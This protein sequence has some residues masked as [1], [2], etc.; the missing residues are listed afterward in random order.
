MEQLQTNNQAYHLFDCVP[1]G[2]CVLDANCRVLFWNDYL[3]ERM[4]VSK[5]E[6]IGQP[7]TAYLPFQQPELQAQLQPVFAGQSVE[8]CLQQ[9]GSFP[10]P[11]AKVTA[12]RLAACD[13]AAA[14]HILLSIQFEANP[15][16]APPFES[17]LLSVRK[18][19]SEVAYWQ[20][21]R[22]TQLL[23]GITAA[24]RDSIDTQQVFQTT[25]NHIACTFQVSRCLIHSYSSEPAPCIPVM[26][27]YVAPGYAPSLNLQVPVSGNPHAEQVL[28]QDRAVAS[29]N[30]TIEP[31]LQN[32]QEL[33]RTFQIR[34][35][36]AVRT[37]YQ[38]EA[39]GVIGLHQCDRLRNWT[40]EEI[41]LLEAVAK[42]VGIV[43]AQTRLLE[44]ERR[45]RQEVT[46]K[47]AALEQARW[48]AEAANQAKSNFLATMSH[49]IR[50]PM[51]A[52]IGMT[53]LLLDTELTPQ[54]QDFVET[55]R[56]SGDTLLTIINDILDFS[57]IEAGKLDLEQR[58][59]DL[60]TCIEGILDL[61]AAKAA[62]KGL[63]LAYVVEPDVPQQILGDMTRLRQILIN[64]IGNAIKFTEQG[65]ITVSVIAR[66]LREEEPINLPQP[67]AQSVYAIRFAVKD[68]GIGIPSDQLNRLFHPFSQ[69]DSSISR[70]YGGTGLG[71]VI[72]QRLSEMM[73][74][75]IWVDSEIGQGSTFYFSIA[76]KAV[77]SATDSF[78]QGHLSLL[79]NKRL[80]IVDS[81]AVSRQNLLLQARCWGMSVQTFATGQDALNWLQQGQAF[82]LALID[83]KLPDF[84]SLAIVAAIR[85]LSAMPLVLLV[86]RNHLTD[87]LPAVRYLHKPVKQSQFYNLLLEVFATTVIESSAASVPA[88]LKLAKQLPLRIL[89][90]ED[91][92]VNQKVVLKLLERLGYKADIAQNGLEVL[93]LLSRQAYDVILMD[94]QMPE[95]DGL[96]AARQIRQRYPAA[97]RPRIIAITAIAMQGDREECLQA[98]MHDYLSKPLRP[99]SLYAALQQCRLH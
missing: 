50:T 5:A 71:L 79:V 64:L 87:N 75:R 44:Q 99:D 19:A 89:V 30:V 52:V 10:S 51:N 9:G 49:E 69:V 65:E 58:P 20:V 95:M 61:L 31:L 90:A 53:E 54:Q 24:I 11:T 93:D 13:P 22:R 15:L 3:A 59:L 7:I 32:V 14:D 78:S 57:K 66:K 38:N 97:Q 82:D 36:L 45:Q 47:N 25:V 86:S 74:G 60:R 46:L 6:T 77:Q 96:T 4:N 73:G 27:E 92:V 37:S 98:G 68:T 72:S 84:D 23:E 1:F 26:I 62:E 85:Q 2:V 12:K 70:Q 42:Q 80:L 29:A 28:A 91:N 35:M 81:N 88:E 67:A 8:L 56:T 21:V 33:C 34:S 16:A 48:E 63:E 41:N 76:A 94:V 55:I 83:R 17:C 40:L 18:D 43:M 39:N